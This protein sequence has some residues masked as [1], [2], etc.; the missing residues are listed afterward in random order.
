MSKSRRNKPIYMATVVPGLENIAFQEICTKFPTAGTVDSQKGKVFFHYENSYKDLFALKCV[1]NIYF[2][3]GSFG[4]GPHKV[5]LLQV[6]SKIKSLNVIN[7]ILQIEKDIKG[8]RIIVSAS[9][10][11]KHTYSRFDIADTFLDALLGYH[12][13]VRGTVEQH[14]LAFRVDV[15]KDKAFLHLKLTPPTFR[16]RGKDREFLTGALRPSVAHSMVLISEP[17]ST[18]VF[19]DPFC[20]SGT[21]PYERAFYDAFAILAS[22][23]SA[24]RLEVARKNLPEYIGINRWDACNTEMID[25]SVTKIVSNLPWGKQ[26]Q[27]DDI[28]QLY[29]NFLKEAKRI[30]AP[31]GRMVLLTDEENAL[32]TAAE[33]NGFSISKVCTIS[34]HGLHP[35]IFMLEK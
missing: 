22:D 24:E 35:S 26:I 2:Y 17:E 30:L 1:D 32:F 10:S 21:I 34:L 33:I 25:N 12:F 8:K 13:F 14:D 7:R 9:R 19:L 29:I 15:D 16:F 20:G 11:G 4:I 6:E 31:G 27:V 3:I 5:D 18:D 28:K 23:I